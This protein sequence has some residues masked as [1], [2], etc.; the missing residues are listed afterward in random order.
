MARTFKYLSLALAQAADDKK[1]EDVVLLDVRRYSPITEYIL[2]ATVTSPPH[3]GAV[4]DAVRTK[5]KELGVPALRR[6]RPASDKWRVLDFGGLLA[7]FMT[8]ETRRFYALEKLY[9][10]AKPM[11]WAAEPAATPSQSDRKPRKAARAR[12]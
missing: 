5:G 12:S 11:A 6:A 1:A 3:L 4:E 2:I 8:E 7:H 9:P 10:L